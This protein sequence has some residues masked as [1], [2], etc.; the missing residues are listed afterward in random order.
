MAFF[1]REKGKPFLFCVFDGYMVEEMSKHWRHLS[2]ISL[3]VHLAYFI[4]REDLFLC[5]CCTLFS[6]AGTPYR[7][8]NWLLGLRK[9]VLLRV[10][11]SDQ[12][13]VIQYCL[14]FTVEPLARAG[15]R[16]DF[17]CSKFS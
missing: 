14:L 4:F 10:V 3:L 7:L 17:N 8:L 13:S 15:L 2:Q 11:P 12:S 16:Q 9:Q 6:A 5:N 1:I